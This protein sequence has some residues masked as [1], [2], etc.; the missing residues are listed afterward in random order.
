M[1]NAGKRHGEEA[2]RSGEAEGQ[3]RGGELGAETEMET[4]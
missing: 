4:E 2:A 1:G 3:G